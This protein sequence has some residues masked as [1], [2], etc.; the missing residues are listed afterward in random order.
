[1]CLSVQ[2]CCQGHIGQDTA[3]GILFFG[4]CFFSLSV[5]WL[6]RSKEVAPEE[7]VTAEKDS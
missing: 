6:N 4:G 5:W 3:M 2:H 1:M 7:F